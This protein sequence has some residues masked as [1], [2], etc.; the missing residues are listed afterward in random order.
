MDEVV[1]SQEEWKKKTKSANSYFVGKYINKLEKHLK[2]GSLKKFDFARCLYCNEGVSNE[3]PEWVKCDSCDGWIHQSC[4]TDNQTKNY[5]DVV[6]YCKFCT[7]KIKEI[8]KV[9]LNAFEIEKATR[10]QSRSVMWQAERRKRLTTSNFGEIFKAKTKERCE[11]LVEKYTSGKPYTNESIRYGQN[12]ES[13]AVIAYEKETGLK[14]KQAGLIIHPKF[15]YIAGSPDGLVN[16]DGVI[17]VKCPAS[18][19]N[20]HP[21]MGS[22]YY[23]DADGNL[24]NNHNYFCQIQGLLEVTDR[25]WCDFVVYTSKGLHIQRIRRDRRF[26]TNILSKLQEFY[27]K[28]MLPKLDENISV[29]NNPTIIFELYENGLVNKSNYYIQFPRS[30]GYT[31]GMYRKFNCPELCYTEYKTLNQNAWLSDVVIELALNILNNGECLIIY[32]NYSTETFS[33]CFEGAFSKLILKKLNLCRNKMLV[34]PILINANH[35]CIAFADLKLKKFIFIN[36]ADNPNTDYSKVQNDCDTYMKRFLKFMKLYNKSNGTDFNISEWSFQVVDHIV[37]SDS[38]NCG[39]FIIYFFKCFVN[40]SP[41]THYTAISMFRDDIKLI[42]QK[43]SENMKERCLIC[44]KETLENFKQCISCK[45][46]IHNGEC[47]LKAQVLNFTCFL[48]QKYR[49]LNIET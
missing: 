41:L 37:Q 8:E 25:N 42:I 17:E 19:K 21:L 22:L 14:V 15:N 32:C 24:K 7:E 29:F 18:I 26:F 11:K 13:K 47:E 12:T 33:E 4:D 5:K 45:R 6:F 23:L 3:K 35:W 44:N 27:F 34:F 16:H 1:H 36:P 31:I 30:K 2:E 9:N 38:F 46:L 10:D 48:C 39:G 49:E 20:T 40:N 43:N 28:Y